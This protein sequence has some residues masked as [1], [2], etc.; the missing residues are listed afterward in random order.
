LFCSIRIIGYTSA[1]E[2]ASTYTDSSGFVGITT[3]SQL[4]DMY[5][6]VT[7]KSK[8]K[9]K[10][11]KSRTGSVTSNGSTHSGSSGTETEMDTSSIAIGELSFNF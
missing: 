5:G 6:E 8:K 4:P 3:D 10:K 9:K 11:K 7:V 1:Y 2:N